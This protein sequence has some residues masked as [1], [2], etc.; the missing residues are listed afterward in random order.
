M[1]KT[2]A[3]TLALLAAVALASPQKAIT[4]YFPGYVFVP[5]TNEM[6]T[7]GMSTGAAYAVF[8]LTDLTNGLTAAKAV[9]AGSTSDVR[10]VIG[11]FLEQV[12]SVYF[13]TASSNRPAM[14]ESVRSVPAT[15][16]TNITV[17]FQV[18]QKYGVG[19]LVLE[20]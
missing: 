13:A 4:N 20:D 16:A 19:V 10:A 6:G 14:F 12:R 1:K 11:A 7:T 2:I 18:D 9:P 8:A 15:S 3:L 17:R 5:G